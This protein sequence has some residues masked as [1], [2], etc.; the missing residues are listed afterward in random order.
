MCSRSRPRHWCMSDCARVIRRRAFLSPLKL[1][2]LAGLSADVLMVSSRESTVSRAVDAL[3]R[4]MTRQ[5]AASVR[6][7]APRGPPPLP[8]R[9]PRTCRVHTFIGRFAKIGSALARSVFPA[10]TVASPHERSRSLSEAGRKLFTAS[11]QKRKTH[12]DADR[13]RKYLARFGLDWS[14]VQA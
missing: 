3:N 2:T 10:L 5:R 12:N 9:Q 7:R 8:A 1:A 11:R 4:A 13:L 6:R 14:A